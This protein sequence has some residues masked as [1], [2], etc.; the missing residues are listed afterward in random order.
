MGARPR[1]DSKGGWGDSADFVTGLHILSF[2]FGV[3]DVSFRLPNL[4]STAKIAN[5]KP[6]L[7]NLTA[8]P[9]HHGHLAAARTAANTAAANTRACDHD[10]SARCK[11]NS[12]GQKRKRDE[13]SSLRPSL[14]TGQPCFAAPVLL[15]GR[16]A[17][18]ALCRNHA[19][20]GGLRDCC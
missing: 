16:T 14:N 15:H 6:I 8:A 12:R 11:Q 20:L 9:S 10:R 18:C 4:K 19:L 17:D 13:G 2:S 1:Q 3:W 5:A 7:G